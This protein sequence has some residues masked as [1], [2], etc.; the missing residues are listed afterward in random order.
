VGKNSDREELFNWAITEFPEINMLINNA[1]IQKEVDFTEGAKDLL[2][3]ENEIEI[4]FTGSVHLA[5]LFIPYFLEQ[6][7]ECAVVNITSGLAFIPLK[8]IPVYC[9]TKAGLHAFSIA[10]RSQLDKTNV[11]VFEIAPPIVK[12]GLHRGERAIK[13]SERGIS[14]EAVA[15]ASMKALKKDRYEAIIGEAKSL[16]GASRIAPRFFHKLLNKVAAD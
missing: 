16:K 9:G 10:L 1:G 3:E 7:R 11:R 12:T 15:K 14:A 6:S 13:Q 8:I 2:G 5:S 4:N